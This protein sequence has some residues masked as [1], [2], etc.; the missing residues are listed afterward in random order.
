LELF[1]AVTLTG[2]CNNTVKY[3]NWLADCSVSCLPM[4]IAFLKSD[5]NR[6]AIYYSAA[7]TRNLAF[8]DNQRA[9]RSCK[10]NN[11]D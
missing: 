11:D 8:A 9:R 5:W 3:C 4:H 1:Y 10:I 2:N 6:P 7:L